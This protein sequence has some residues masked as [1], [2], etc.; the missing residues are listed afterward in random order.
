MTRKTDKT[1][2]FKIKT[3]RRFNLT[4]L[5]VK[6]STIRELKFLQSDLILNLLLPHVVTY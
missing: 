6:T 4:I 5:K 3:L 1:N 2:C